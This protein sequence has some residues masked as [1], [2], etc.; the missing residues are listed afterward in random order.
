MNLQVCLQ[1]LFSRVT[2]LAG[3]RSLVIRSGTPGTLKTAFAKPYILPAPGEDLYRN[4]SQSVRSTKLDSPF[5]VSSPA[6]FE[7]QDATDFNFEFALSSDEPVNPSVEGG[8]GFHLYDGT[9]LLALPA[10]N[11]SQALKANHACIAPLTTLILCRLRLR[12]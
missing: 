9:T 2:T 10:P 4:P 5:A 1:V 12:D 8:A 11:I 6:T 3:P 7:V